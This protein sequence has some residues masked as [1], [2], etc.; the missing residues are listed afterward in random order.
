M[1]YQDIMKINNPIL[2][3]SKP[4]PIRTEH[5][6]DRIKSILDKLGYTWTQRYNLG[7]YNVSQLL[8][9]TIICEDNL[10]IS[11]DIIDAR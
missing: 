3:V 8:P 9:F 10:K 1:Q 11:L 4:I 2:D 5:E 6:Y 7:D